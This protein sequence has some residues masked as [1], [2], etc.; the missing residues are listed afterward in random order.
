M[1]ERTRGQHTISDSW[2][3][4][5]GN[6]WCRDKSHRRAEFAR[7]ENGSRRNH[8]VPSFSRRTSSD[9]RRYRTGWRRFEIFRFFSFTCRPGCYVSRHTR[10]VS[11]GLC[12]RRPYIRW[13]TT[14]T[15][16]TF[17]G[18]LGRETKFNSIRSVIHR[19]LVNRLGFRPRY[20]PL[21]FRC[22]FFFFF[23]KNR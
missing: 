11:D 5:N 4:S 21:R 2:W 14:T 23:K 18:V 7:V 15:I 9:G 10:N 16:A 3:C 22:F 1:V 17:T 20:I 6:E 19:R 12:D 8:R 13:T